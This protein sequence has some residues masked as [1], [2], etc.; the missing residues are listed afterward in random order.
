MSSQSSYYYQSAVDDF[1][2]ARRQAAMQQ[3]LARFTGE[4][5]ELLSYDDI[6][7]S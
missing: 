2:Q 3:L 4:S 7:K 1:H 5:T 6:R